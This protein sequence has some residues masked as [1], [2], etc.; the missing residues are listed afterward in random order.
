MARRWSAG[1]AS[2]IFGPCRLLCRRSHLS[3]K[4]L[5]A[6]PDRWAILV[7]NTGT[8]GDCGYYIKQA[9]CTPCVPPC[10]N[11]RPGRLRWLVAVAFCTITSPYV[12]LF[13]G[14]LAPNTPRHLH[15]DLLTSHCSVVLLRR[16]RRGQT[17]SPVEMRRRQRDG[18]FGGRTVCRAECASA[19]GMPTVSR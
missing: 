16:S 2:Q 1:R 18:M 8:R 10:S 4:D 11:P 5:I 6:Q 7:L 13:H 14:N 19:L 12:D 9:Y 15:C 17:R 3:T